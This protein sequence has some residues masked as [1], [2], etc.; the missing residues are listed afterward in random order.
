MLVGAPGT[1]PT[2][3]WTAHQGV[4]IE[5]GTGADSTIARPVLG[6]LRFIG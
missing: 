6:S 2:L 3:D 1:H 4:S 5:L